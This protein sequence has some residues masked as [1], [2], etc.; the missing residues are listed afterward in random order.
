MVTATQTTLNALQLEAGMGY[1]GMFFSESFQ[2]AI[3]A[4]ATGG[5]ANATP[6]TRQN[7]RITT[8]A[9]PG[10][11]VKLPPALPGLEVFAINH[12]ANSAQVFGNGS[13]QINDVASNVGVSMMQNSCVLF[14]CMS[15][16]LWYTADLA[17]GFVPGS[18]GGFAT[19]AVQSGVACTAGGNQG[20]STL[21][22]AMN[23]QLTGP[24]SGAS[25]FLLPPAKPGMEVTIVNNTG[26]A[27]APTAFGS[28]SDTING[29]AGA[30]GVATGGNGTVTIYYV[31][32]A[33]A[34]VTK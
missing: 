29:T 32:V 5:Q 34:W 9:N 15:A 18:G 28:G 17:S 7:N 19:F 27:T 20:N 26:N 22:T 33:G 11:S 1:N 31:F 14:L 25:G 3:T 23:A 6:L 16:G 8:V 2:D 13:D 12:G 21:I 24:A 30:T 4:F 10:D